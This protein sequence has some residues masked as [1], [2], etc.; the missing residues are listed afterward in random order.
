MNKKNILFILCSIILSI[1]LFS[2]KYLHNIKKPRFNTVGYESS[3]IGREFDG[4]ANQSF[5]QRDE[6]DAMFAWG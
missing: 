1:I 5:Y 3:D 4:E 2:I 6:W